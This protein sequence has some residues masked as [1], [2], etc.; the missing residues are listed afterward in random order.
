MEDREAEPARLG[1][2]CHEIHSEVAAI[3]LR[4]KSALVVEQPVDLV[5]VAVWDFLVRQL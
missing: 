4:L 3:L 5:Q 1:L 2:R